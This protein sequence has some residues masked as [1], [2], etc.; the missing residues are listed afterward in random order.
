MFRRAAARARASDTETPT[1]MERATHLVSIR[2]GPVESSSMTARA[3]RR[4]HGSDVVAEVIAIDAGAWQVRVWRTN[5]P[6]TALRSPHDLDS[7]TAARE[8]A[9]ELAR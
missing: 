5:S 9:D 6:T 3:W 7:A 8:N 1:I 4:S 2:T